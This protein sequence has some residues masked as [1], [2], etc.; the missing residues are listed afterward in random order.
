[1]E[2]ST[3]S[4]VVTSDFF[5]AAGVPLIAGRYFSADDGQ[6][7]GPRAVILSASAARKLGPD[8]HALVGQR[9]VHESLPAEIVGIVRDVR[10]FGPVN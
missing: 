4:V 5:R 8:V 2:A 1:M 10:M 7:G 9:L 3:T 6:P